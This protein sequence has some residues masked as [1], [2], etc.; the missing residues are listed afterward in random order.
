MSG[1]HDVHV[2]LGSRGNE[3]VVG[4]VSERDDLLLATDRTDRS[5]MQNGGRALC[6]VGDVN[7]GP[8]RS[9]LESATTELG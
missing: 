5:A 9:V 6:I 3:V 2:V 1:H 4:T 7:D 8:L